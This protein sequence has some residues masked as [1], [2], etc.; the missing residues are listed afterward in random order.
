V[1]FSLLR[2][3]MNGTKHI[4]ASTGASAP[5]SARNAHRGRDRLGASLGAGDARRLP[6]LAR[7]RKGLTTHQETRLNECLSRSER[8]RVLSLPGHGF[9]STPMQTVQPSMLAS[10]CSVG[11]LRWQASP[12]DC[13][14]D[15]TSTFPPQLRCGVVAHLS[16]IARS[17]LYR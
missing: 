13:T 16:R 7:S 3:S 6:R 11:L 2:R 10:R 4:V 12:D 14:V 8:R 17:K 5:R 1:V 9:G 15:E